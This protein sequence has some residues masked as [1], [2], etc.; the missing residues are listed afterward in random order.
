[1]AKKKEDCLK[2]VTTSKMVTTLKIATTSKMAT[3][4]KNCDNIKNEGILKQN[5]YDLKKKGRQPHN[6]MVGMKK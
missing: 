4:S 3:S 6:L 1:M 2:M 5:E